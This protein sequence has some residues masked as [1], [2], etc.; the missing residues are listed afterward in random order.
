MLLR[1]ARPSDVP[2]LGPV[3]V[4]SGLFPSGSESFLEEL[5]TASI[6]GGAVVLV[7]EG[8]AGTPA[9]V[10]LARPEEATDRAWDLT[11]LAVRADQQRTGLGGALMRAVEQRLVEEG[12]RLLLVRTSS[13]EEFAGARAFYPRLGYE[14]EA[15]IRDRWADGD[16]DVTFRKR[17]ADAAAPGAGS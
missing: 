14:E 4:S 7:A 12:Q 15:R 2:H 13:T 10:A 3:A 11:L 1:D 5:F 6:E 9:A 17:L 16:D 8:A